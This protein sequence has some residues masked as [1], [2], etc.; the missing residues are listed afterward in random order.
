MPRGLPAPPTQRCTASPNKKFEGSSARSKRTH[1]NRSR[2]RR[3]LHHV[4]LVEDKNCTDNTI[5]R[6]CTRTSSKPRFNRA[7]RYYQ[8]ILSSSST[9][10]GVQ[11]MRATAAAAAAFATTNATQLTPHANYMLDGRWPDSS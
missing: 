8:I 10:T 2:I 3:S 7:L 11:K 9:Q 6:G 5:A 1:A 4:T